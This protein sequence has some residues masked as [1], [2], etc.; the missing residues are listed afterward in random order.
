MRA[1]ASCRSCSWARA[2][3][4]ASLLPEDP[5]QPS[6]T[7]DPDPLRFLL[8]HVRFVLP[9]PED[10]DDVD[11]AIRCLFPLAPRGPRRASP[12]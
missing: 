12:A 9:L 1:A 3:I 6:R 5:G 8:G 11:H 2:T 7:S 10:L 4:A